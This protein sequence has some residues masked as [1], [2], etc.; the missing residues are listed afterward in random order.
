MMVTDSW[1]TERQNFLLT[2]LGVTYKHGGCEVQ[3]LQRYY[4]HLSASI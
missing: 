3:E 1:L 4:V 2:S